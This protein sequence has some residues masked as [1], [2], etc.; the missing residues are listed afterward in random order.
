MLRRVPFVLSCAALAVALA[1][2][3]GIGEAAQELVLP[4]DSVGTA[5]LRDGAV[6]GA[7]VKDRSLL[8][9]DFKQGQLPRGP[10]GPPGP[11]GTIEGVAAGGDLAGTYPSPELAGDAVESAQVKDGSLLLADTAVLGGQVRVNPPSVAAHACLS[12]SAPVRGVEPYD[13]TLV[14]PTQNLSSGLFVT[15]MFNT[16][17]PDRVLFRV[18]NAMAKAFDTQAG[19]WAYVVWR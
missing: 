1:G 16:N 10:Q 4:R 5:Q 13:R 11:A 17:T 7:K 12:L 9:R 15:Q 2:A 14:L 19:A 3:T 6:T 8:A 18:C